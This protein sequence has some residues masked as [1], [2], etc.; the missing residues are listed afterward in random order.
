MARLALKERRILDFPHERNPLRR[1][2][3]PC[4]LGARM[5][6]LLLIGFLLV[7]GIALMV[8]DDAI[9]HAEEGYEDST[10]FHQE[11]RSWSIA[12]TPPDSGITIWDQVEGACCRLDMS[13]HVRGMSRSQFSPPKTPGFF[14]PQ[15]Q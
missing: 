2:N 10:G 3:N 1:W 7:L 13:P 12:P 11:S 14:G 8:L 5:I 4:S 15:N 6:L 9:E